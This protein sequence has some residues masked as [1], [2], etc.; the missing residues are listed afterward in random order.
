VLLAGRDLQ[1]SLAETVEAPERRRSPVGRHRVVARPEAHPHE[2]LQPRARRPAEPV[3]VRERLLEDSALEAAPDG[4]RTETGLQKLSAA[5]KA[6]LSSC[7][8]LP[9]HNTI[10]KFFFCFTTHSA[11]KQNLDVRD[12]FSLPGRSGNA[13]AQQAFTCRTAI[14]L[15]IESC[16]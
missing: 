2:G 3:H 8:C 11:V 1:R 12:A 6:M 5:D 4:I 9:L 7:Q 14:S 15:Q 16:V 10:L 13:W